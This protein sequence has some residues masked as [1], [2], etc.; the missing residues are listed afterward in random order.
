LQKIEV[1]IK[2]YVNKWVKDADLRL[3]LRDLNGKAVFTSDIS[4]EQRNL[5]INNEVKAVAEIPAHFLRPGSFTFTI[6]T[7][8]HNQ[9]T[10]HLLEDV[11]MMDV[12]DGGSKYAASEGL[13]YGYIFFDPKWSLNNVL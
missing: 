10:I 1:V 8:V 12:A 7:L 6:V 11:L 2:L 4:L 13:D 9:F 5:S 3:V